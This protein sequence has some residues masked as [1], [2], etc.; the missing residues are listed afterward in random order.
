MPSFKL[1]YTHTFTL[2]S[3][4]PSSSKFLMK[5]EWAYFEMFDMSEHY[6]EILRTSD[7]VNINFPSKVNE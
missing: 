3:T 2:T 6:F 5:N 4:N 7:N 1:I